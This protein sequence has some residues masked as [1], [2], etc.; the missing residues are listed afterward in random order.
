MFAVWLTTADCFAVLSTV[1]N[2]FPV[3]LDDS[4]LMSRK[5]FVGIGLAGPSAGLVL[6]SV[7]RL[8][9]GL[10]EARGDSPRSR[11]TRSAMSLTANIMSRAP[12]MTSGEYMAN[13]GMEDSDI[14]EE[15][16]ESIQHTC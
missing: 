13:R 16:T 7:I 3:P 5:G 2:S 14:Q 12:Q 9:K 11:V 10:L 15:T 6:L 1:G 4:S 8:R